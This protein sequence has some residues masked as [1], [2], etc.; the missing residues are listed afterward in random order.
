MWCRGLL[1]V[2][3]ATVALEME[4]AK[5]ADRLRS[6]ILVTMRARPGWHA[7]QG[8]RRR[9]SIGGHASR[10]TCLKVRTADP[11]RTRWVA[12]PQAGQAL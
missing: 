4:A 3:S 8:V 6:A 1:S 9:E 7:R 11:A 12:I 2:G 5:A 10:T